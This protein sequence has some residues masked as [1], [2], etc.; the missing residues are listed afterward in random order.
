MELLLDDLAAPASA[1]EVPEELVGHVRYLFG[2][3]QE[4]TDNVARLSR[5]AV[6]LRW[7]DGYLAKVTLAGKRCQL[8]HGALIQAFDAL[9]SATREY[10]RGLA[11]ALLT[12]GDGAS[13]RA[14]AMPVRLLDQSS[15]EEVARLREVCERALTHAADSCQLAPAS[16]TLFDTKWPI[17][18]SEVTVAGPDVYLGEVRPMAWT[19]CGPEPL[20]HVDAR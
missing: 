16:H 7:P 10:E 17:R 4:A 2:L 13:A 12:S 1:E 15:S 6:Q 9:A 3:R 11:A 14:Y 19:G 20:L 8:A 18:R 5:H